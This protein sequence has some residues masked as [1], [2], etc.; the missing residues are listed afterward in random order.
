MSSF[1]WYTD[2]VNKVTPT[3]FVSVA[4]GL[5]SVGGIEISGGGAGSGKVLQVVSSQLLDKVV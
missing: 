3:G 1:R 4:L 2:I 5:L